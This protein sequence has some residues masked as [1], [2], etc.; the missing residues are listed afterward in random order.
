[1]REFIDDKL[2]YMSPPSVV[3]KYNVWNDGINNCDNRILTKRE[4][5]FA[6]I[7]DFDAD[8][9]ECRLPLDF[10]AVT[11]GDLDRTAR[12]HAELV[13]PNSPEWVI[14]SEAKRLRGLMVLHD[15]QNQA[16]TLKNHEARLKKDVGIFSTSLNELNLEMWDKFGDLGT[17]YCVGLK[18]SI[19]YD[20][21]LCSM[22][23]V[24]YYDRSNPPKIFPLSFSDEERTEKVWQQFSSIPKD[25]GFEEEFRFTKMIRTKIQPLP[26]SY[27]QG[28]RAFVLPPEAFV[29]VALGPSI[30][31]ED[32]GYIIEVVNEEFSDLPVYKLVFNRK[33]KE[34]AK[35]LIV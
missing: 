21:I 25:L 29:E 27:I 26:S 3:Y 20:N 9:P 6:S 34:F 18:P 12:Y 16:E 1:M 22:G 31:D 10:D 17:G 8:Y 4:I 2:Q 11:E 24:R 35:E 28:Q 7:D 33:T 32:K 19:I 13:R 23:R 14:K 15:K 5:Y 30:S